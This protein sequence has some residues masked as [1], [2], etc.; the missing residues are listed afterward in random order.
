M[1]YRYALRKEE[2][3]REES[4]LSPILR[5]IGL[6]GFKRAALERFTKLPLSPYEKL[7]GLE[8]LRALEDGMRIAI[9]KVKPPR[10]SSPGI[11]T[12]DDLARAEA[13][14]EMYGD[15]FTS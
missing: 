13:L 5:H 2:R 15:P 6:Y 7:E 8:Q 12:P 10:I 3:L 14:I 11:D 9:V 1:R 4:P